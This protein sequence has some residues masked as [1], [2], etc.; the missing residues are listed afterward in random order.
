MHDIY[1]HLLDCM[2]HG[3]FPNKSKHQRGEGSGGVGGGEIFTFCTGW[4]M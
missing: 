1:S 4:R 2:Y 3:C